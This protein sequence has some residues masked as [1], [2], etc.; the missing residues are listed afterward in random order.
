MN[1]YNESHTYEPAVLLN[2][3]HIYSLTSQQLHV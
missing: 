3:L 2:V 1:S